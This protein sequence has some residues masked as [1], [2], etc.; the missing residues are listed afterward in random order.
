MS[1]RSSDSQVLY[2]D[3]QEENRMLY[4]QVEQEETMSGWMYMR[5]DDYML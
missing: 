3:L 4:R 5:P 2:I 1:R